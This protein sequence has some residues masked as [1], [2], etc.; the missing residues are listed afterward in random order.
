MDLDAKDPVKQRLELKDMLRNVLEEAR[1]VLPG[2]QALFG[3]QLISV[4]N[5]TFQK[6]SACDK[7]VHF[8]AL[9]LTIF[10]IGALMGP[11]SYHRQVERHSVSKQFIDYSSLL[12]CIGI[13]PLALSIA[14]DTYVVS[15]MM[16]QLLWP[17]IVAASLAFIT[18]M[19]FWYF[20][21]QAKKRSD[22]V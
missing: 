4:F 10:S 7:Y 6:L 15:H 5:D 3:F 20:I 19:I 8:A 22:L 16:T 12:L 9:L 18:L 17:A 1:M 13:F 21:P 14:L 11:A 2:I